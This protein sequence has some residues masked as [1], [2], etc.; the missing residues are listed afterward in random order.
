LGS[1]ESVDVVDAARASVNT[2]GYGGRGVPIRAVPCSARPDAWSRIVMGAG[3]VGGVVSC[4]MVWEDEDHDNV[5]RGTGIHPVHPCGE[6]TPTPVRGMR[7]NAAGMH[8]SGTHPP[9]SQRAGTS[10]RC[11]SF[12]KKEAKPTEPARRL[13][14]SIALPH[15]A[16]PATLLREPR[17]ARAPNAEASKR[18]TFDSK[19]AAAPSRAMISIHRLGG[20]TL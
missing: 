14:H 13:Q 12:A 3:G 17:S 16:L 1:G 6:C 5:A 7:I 2:Y 11:S 19:P 20:A 4:G 15:A 8:S 10:K 9:A 18:A